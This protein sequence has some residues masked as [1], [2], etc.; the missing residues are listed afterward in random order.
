M[1]RSKIAVA[2]IVSMMSTFSYAGSNGTAITQDQ[3]NDYLVYVSTT[4]GVCGGQLIAGKYVVTAA[5]CVAHNYG[6][7]MGDTWNAVPVDGL[8]TPAQVAAA[9]PKITFGNVNKTAGTVVSVNSVQ[10]HPE[11]VYRYQHDASA[12]SSY[13]EQETTAFM[14]QTGVTD[15]QLTYGKPLIV[16]DIVVFELSA[17]VLQ[18]SSA[19]LIKSDKAIA[20]KTDITWA[21]WG[22]TLSNQS[23]TPDV[24][25]TG[26][27]SYTAYPYSNWTQIIG[28]SMDIEKATTKNGSNLCSGDSGSPETING[29]VIGYESS[30]TFSC[31][32]ANSVSSLTSAPF[33]LPWLAQQINAVNTV[34][35]KELVVTSAG[36]QSVTWTIPVQNLKTTDETFTPELIDSTGLFTSNNLSNCEGTFATGSACE[37]SV[38]FNAAGAQVANNATATLKLNSEVSI[39]LSYLIQTPAPTPSPSNGGNSGGSSGGGSTSPYVLAGMLALSLVRRIR[40][41]TQNK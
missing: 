1:K 19:T 14:N 31:G 10:I 32:D 20:D 21:G 8:L 17:P 4:G 38:T 16:G 35:K 24:A 13:L 22:A 41:H 29:Q 27:I 28:F 11:Y 23:A 40:C 37:I 34:G 2:V 6:A 33:Y 26:T 30:S 9:N 15:A 25:N 7:A 3:F 5:H 36:T 12:R 18:Q 39:P